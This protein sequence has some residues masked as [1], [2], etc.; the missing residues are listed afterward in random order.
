MRNQER[1]EEEDRHQQKESL[2][3]PLNRVYTDID[4]AIESFLSPDENKIEKDEDKDMF[5]GREEDLAK[6]DMFMDVRTSESGAASTAVVAGDDQEQ[7]LAL[8]QNTANVEDIDR[9]GAIPPSPDGLS[10]P[11]PSHEEFTNSI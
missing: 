2:S 11:V 4:N 9:S 3:S 8:K 1:E 7:S 6:D 10:A 5:A